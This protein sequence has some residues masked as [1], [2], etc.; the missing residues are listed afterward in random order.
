MKDLQVI[1]KIQFYIC[2]C[3]IEGDV[4]SSLLFDPWSQVMCMGFASVISYKL[5]CLSQGARK[6]GIAREVVCV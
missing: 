5:R 6:H 3:I 2:F 1:V 4:T